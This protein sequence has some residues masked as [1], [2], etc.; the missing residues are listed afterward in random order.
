MKKKFY[1]ITAVLLIIL[2]G[3]VLVLL[4]N[5]NNN[6][7]GNFSL[8]DYQEQLSESPS[9]LVLGETLDSKSAKKKAEEVWVKTYG[10]S[11]KKESSPY[12]V[13][14]DDTNNVWLVTGTLPKGWLGG[15][16]Y[17]LIR[18]SDGKVLA[19]WHDF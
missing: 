2:I 15:V 19:M 6:K 3:V 17:I 1:I 14:F 16:P 4:N 5:R 18:K 13:Y 12:E 9:D 8:S 10:K 7:I 11:V